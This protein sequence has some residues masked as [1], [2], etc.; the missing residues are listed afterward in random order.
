MTDPRTVTDPETTALEGYPPIHG[1]DDDGECPCVHCGERGS[2]INAVRELARQLREVLDQCK[3]QAARLLA[4]EADRDRL[5]AERDDADTRWG[6]VRQ[7][8]QY[9]EA[10][11]QINHFPFDVNKTAPEDLMA[12]KEVARA[13][14]A[15]P[16]TPPD[17]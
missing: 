7:A 12:I 1:P 8:D 13:A 10:L 9:R 16:D 2:R 3:T 4:A 11:E 15:T 14:L 17:A 6:R 5:Q